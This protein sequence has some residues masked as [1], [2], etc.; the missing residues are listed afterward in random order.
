MGFCARVWA[1][2][3]Q[4][5]VIVEEKKMSSEKFFLEN[6]KTCSARLNDEERRNQSS[7]RTL[8]Q[9]SCSQEKETSLSSGSVGFQGSFSQELSDSKKKKNS[10][11]SYQKACRHAIQGILIENFLRTG[12]QKKGVVQ[13]ENQVLIYNQLSIL[14]N[15]LTER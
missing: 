12:F 8:S 14:K 2:P 15:G 7:D 10:E 11:N 4:K 6:L 3:L 13:S 9:N 5:G 1:H